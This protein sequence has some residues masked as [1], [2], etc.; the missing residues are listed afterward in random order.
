M[1]LS[2]QNMACKPEFWQTFRFILE[3]AEEGGVYRSPDFAQDPQVY[4]GVK[5]DYNPRFDANTPSI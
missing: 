4:C 2:G 3:A 1:T 5:V